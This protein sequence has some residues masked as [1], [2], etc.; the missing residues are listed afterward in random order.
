MSPRWSILVR[1]GPWEGAN[2]I[3]PFLP[4]WPFATSGGSGFSR[5]QG[6]PAKLVAR[7]NQFSWVCL[8]RAYSS[9]RANRLPCV[10]RGNAGINRAQGRNVGETISL[11]PTGTCSVMDR[12]ALGGPHRIQFSQRSNDFLLCKFHSFDN[13][14]R[15]IWAPMSTPLTNAVRWRKP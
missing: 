5:C 3:S 10:L 8:P 12:L 11:T 2:C 4:R 6:H 7:C 1:N 13:L 9:W 14:L 15:R